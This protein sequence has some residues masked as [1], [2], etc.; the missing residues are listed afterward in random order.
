MC[1]LMI[2]YKDNIPITNTKDIQF[3]QP[4]DPVTVPSS[5][6]H[7]PIP[8]NQCPDFHGSAFLWTRGFITTWELDSKTNSWPYHRPTKLESVGVEPSNQGF[9]KPSGWFWCVPNWRAV[10]F[11]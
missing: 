9:E 2:Y 10:A 4:P 3:G 5:L 8:R 11:L 7:R 1:S 6:S